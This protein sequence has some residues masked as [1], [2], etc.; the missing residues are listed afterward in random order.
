VVIAAPLL[1]DA[2]VVG[3]AGGQ[4]GAVLEDGAQAAED[5]L[6]TAEET[7]QIAEELSQ[8]GQIHGDALLVRQVRQ[9]PE[10]RETSGPRSRGRHRTG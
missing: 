1:S 5:V 9:I 3:N 7:G 8:S 10:V 2:Y 6:E 4:R